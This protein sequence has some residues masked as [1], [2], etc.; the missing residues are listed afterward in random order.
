MVIVHV[1]LCFLY[2]LNLYLQGQF[3]R[4]AETVLV[5][6]IV[7]SLSAAGVMSGWKIAVL[8]TVLTFPLIWILRPIAQRLAQRILGRRVGIASPM[9]KVDP[10]QDL[11]NG[12]SLDQVMAQ[13]DKQRESARRKLRRLMDRPVLKK[14]LEEQEIAEKDYEELWQFLSGSALADLTWDILSNPGDLETLIV[15][16]REGSS[17]PEIWARFRE[18]ESKERIL[19]M[20][21][22][23][24]CA[25]EI[26]DEAIKCRYCGEMLDRTEL[27]EPDCHTFTHSQRADNLGALVIVLL[28]LELC[29]EPLITRDELRE[30]V[31]D[32]FWAIDDLLNKTRERKIRRITGPDP[33]DVLA[34][35]LKHLPG[36]ILSPPELSQVMAIVRAER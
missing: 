1:I 5:F 19:A 8:L 2:A 33:R 18:L 20:R 7:A 23:P 21:K 35:L 12:A 25:E 10:S 31:A 16:R 13:L 30:A 11:A 32:A 34:L 4:Q 28:N 27:I 9:N 26:Q 15:M 3:R 17:V 22:C 14:V 6:L 29:R 24:F 36:G